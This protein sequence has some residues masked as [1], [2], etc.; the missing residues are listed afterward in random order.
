MLDDAST[1]ETPA[2][3]DGGPAGIPASGWSTRREPG[4]GP[5][6]N[7]LLTPPAPATPSS[8]TP[9]TPPSPAASPRST[10]CPPGAAAHLR[11]GLQAE[12]DGAALGAVSN[13]PPT[14]PSSAPTTSTQWP[15]ATWPSTG[16]WAAGPR[17]A[18][19]AR[20]RLGLVHQ[21]VTAGRL[22]AFVPLAAVYRALPTGSTTPCPTPGS[23]RSASPGCSTPSAGTGATTSAAFAVHPDR[24]ALGHA[25]GHRP[26][27]PRRADPAAPGAARRPPAARSSSGPV[28]W[29]NLGD[30]AITARA[31]DHRAGRP[32]SPS[33][34]SPT[35]TGR[36]PARD[37]RWLGTL[38]M[39]VGGLIRRAASTTNGARR[40]PAPG[41]PP[42]TVDRS[43]PALPRRRVPGRRQPL[44]AVGRGL[45]APV[46]VLASALRTPACRT[47]YAGKGSPLDDADRG[48]VDARRWR[49]P[50][51]RPGPGR[52][53]PPRRWGARPPATTPCL[54]DAGPP[55]RGGRRPYL[56]VSLRA[57]DDVGA[58][59]A[60]LGAG[61]SPPTPA[62]ERGLFVLGVPSTPRPEPPR[63]TTSRLPRTGPPRR[64]RGACRLRRGP[65]SGRRGVAGAV[66]VATQSYHAALLGLIAG[67]P[68]VLGAAWPYYVAKADGLAGWPGCRPRSC[69]AR[70]SRSTSR[71]ASSG[72]P[73]R[74]TPVRRRRRGPA[75]WSG[76]GR[77]HRPA[78]SPARPGLA[79]QRLSQSA[80][81][82]KGHV[83]GSS[84]GPRAGEDR[85][86]LLALPDHPVLLA[87]DG[88]DLLVGPELGDP[89]RSARLDA[90]ELGQLGRA[91]VS[92]AGRARC[93]W[94]TRRPAGTRPRAPRRR[95]LRAC[96]APRAAPVPSTSPSGWA[97]STRRFPRG[98][99]RRRAGRPAVVAGS[100][101]D[102]G[103]GPRRG[104]RPRGARRGRSGRRA[105]RPPRARAAAP[106]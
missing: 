102:G 59:E 60:D 37:R 14:A 100:S 69:A 7:A 34:S 99:G 52:R 18:A 95:G 89:R 82:V 75:S 11:H 32:T 55:G 20:R 8:S 96:G 85:V 5:R 47:W 43:T 45:V 72:W 86:G 87:G 48:L 91:S 39:A 2:V 70:A 21:V 49:R 22:L 57:A 84:T 16:T 46:P 90:V 3:A 35:A 50:R 56:V 53:R 10:A 36:R 65:A 83:S 30:D 9:T 73:S 61:R 68:S 54:L 74:S 29:T 1:D 17:P 101:P 23:G 44:V 66:A 76:G 67:V 78:C 15:S 79:G 42:R 81:P 25:R 106:G 80:A 58:A 62:V 105:H 12:A 94:G 88:L 98:A 93:G 51:S 77:G 41:R 28:A 26:R 27:P 104:R 13:E 103:R 63:S 4:P 40:P 92:S 97:P 38:H 71:A 31:L 6:P 24:P 33:T 19:R 64:P